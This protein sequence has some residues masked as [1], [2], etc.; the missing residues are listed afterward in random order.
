MGTVLVIFSFFQM[1][2]DLVCVPRPL[3]WYPPTLATPQLRTYFGAELKTTGTIFMNL[4]DIVP[5]NIRV[6]NLR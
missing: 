3:M 4:W 6:T 2:N 5:N 1:D